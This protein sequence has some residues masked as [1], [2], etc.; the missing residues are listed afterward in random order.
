MRESG[1]QC[2]YGGCIHICTC[3]QQWILLLLVARIGELQSTT[4]PPS[5]PS[6]VNESNGR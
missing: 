5:L 6:A 3:S 1:S 2:E 4:E